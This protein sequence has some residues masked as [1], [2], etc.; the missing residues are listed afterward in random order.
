M[1]SVWGLLPQQCGST[2]PVPGRNCHKGE[3]LRCQSIFRIESW[4]PVS[5]NNPLLL[6]PTLHS[7]Y[8][9]KTV[10]MKYIILI[11]LPHSNPA[12]HY[13][14]Q[15]SQQEWFWSSA[16]MHVERVW[17]KSW[18]WQ[19]KVCIFGNSQL[20]CWLTGFH[21]V[22]WCRSICLTGIA[23]TS[24]GPAGCVPCQGQVLKKEAEQAEPETVDPKKQHFCFETIALVLGHCLSHCAVNNDLH[25][26]WSVSCQLTGTSFSF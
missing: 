19:T 3:T 23:S 18:P 8:Q 15:M 26:S 9:K 10:M 1:S 16:T 21:G 14:G 7:E 11:K 17:C 5:R 4:E 22:I 2:L 25:Y 6:F 20:A 24:A 12:S 13:S